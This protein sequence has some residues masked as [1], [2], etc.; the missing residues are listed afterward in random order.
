MVNNKGLKLLEPITVG[1]LEIRNRIIMPA[2]HLGYCPDGLVTD[3]MIGFYRERARGGAGLI[4]VGGCSIDR[5]AYLNM[6]S[7]RG[8]EFIPGHHRLVKVIKEVGAA[9][10]VQLFQPGCYASSKDTGIQ[11]IAPSAVASGL[12]G[13]MP[14]EMTEEDIQEVITG[15]AAAASR[16]VEA[17][18]DM[19]EILASTGYLISQFF[20]PVTNKR[21]DRYGGDFD[22]RARFGEEVIDAVRRAVGER[23][24]IM[25]R[26]SG[27]DFVPGGSTNSEIVRFARK[28]RRAGADAFNVTGGWHQSRIPQIT[29]DVPEGAYVYLA[30]GIKQAVDVPVAACNRINDPWLAEQILREG[31]ADLI[32]MA[33]G[34]L[35]DPDLPQKV[36]E[37][38]FDEIR[39]CIGCNQGCLDQIFSGKSCHCLVNVQAGREDDTRIRPVENRKK[40]LIIGGGPAGMEAARVAALRGHR[41]SLWEKSGTL[42]G[43][44]RL[45]AAVPGRKGFIDLIRYLENSLQR[46]EVDIRLQT[47]ATLERVRDFAPQSIIAASGAAPAVPAITGIEL[48]HVVN[49]W[50]V[51]EGKVELGRRV[52]VVGGG[53]T[54]CEL[55]LY[56]S[57]I[58]TLDSEIVKFL[59]VNEAETVERIKELAT[60]GVKEVTLLEQERTAGKGIGSSTRWIILQ[61]LRRRGVQIRTSTRVSAIEPG[62]VLVETS[63]G[64][65]ERIPAD[66]VVV[67]VGS[68]SENSLYEQLKLE[69]PEVYLIGDAK[70]PRQAVEAMK[71]GFEAG[72]MI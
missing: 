21:T 34:L 7:L 71:E 8:D 35:A 2:M 48:N 72:S 52:V 49:A 59:L 15:F 30:Q 40:V 66:T 36:M 19:V 51:P 28:L 26:L 70:T 41:V 31:K 16:A 61:E 33:R 55:A 4:I 62:G 45:A 43:Q 65:Q 58:G 5:H 46:L 22:N 6:V 38:R 29:M 53:P 11:P 18:Y 47:E 25:V 42:G 50:E 57:A 67:A 68:R 44:L 10:A 13:E 63:D 3:Q 54:G 32:G 69:F 20:S 12:T 24:P 1:N 37:G 64:H 9:A 39:K 23:Y 56:I 17:G 14:R 27:S 60:R